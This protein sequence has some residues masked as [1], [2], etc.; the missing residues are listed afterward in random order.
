MSFLANRGQSLNLNYTLSSNT[1]GSLI[2]S[3]AGNIGNVFR[4]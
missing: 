4:L 1:F 3:T 2:A